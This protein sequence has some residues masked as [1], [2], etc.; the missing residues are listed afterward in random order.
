MSLIVKQ[1]AIDADTSFKC[2][3]FVIKRGDYEVFW[4]KA[5]NICKFLEHRNT[6][7]TLARYVGSAWKTEWRNLKDALNDSSLDDVITVP[8]KWRP[9]TMFVSEPGVYA[10]SAGSNVSKAVR[11]TKW[12]LEEL[13]PELR[14]MRPNTGRYTIQATDEEPMDV[15]VDTVEN[16]F[17][18]ISTIRQS[19]NHWAGRW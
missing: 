18:Q 13:L 12:F 4:F 19:G 10:I 9:N 17:D 11:F 14:R 8:R 15:D 1:F 3:I 5:A 16:G 2:Y 7:D 6:S